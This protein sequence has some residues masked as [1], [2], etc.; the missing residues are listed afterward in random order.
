MNEE[1]SLCHLFVR[2][3][4]APSFPS[5]N[6]AH[7]VMILCYEL[8]QPSIRVEGPLPLLAPSEHLER[9]FEQM[10]KTLTGIGFLDPNHPEKIVGTLRRIFVKGQLDTREVRILRGIWS[11]VDWSIKNKVKG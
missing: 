3:P 10:G 9:M 11:Q 8:S 7:A 4:A 1:L 2:I 6:L 5:L